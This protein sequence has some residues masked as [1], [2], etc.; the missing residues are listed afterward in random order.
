MSIKNYTTSISEDKTV[1]E[2]MGLLA[3][4]GARSIRIDYDELN[5]PSAVSFTVVIQDWPVPF[6]LPC[7]FDGVFKAM[8]A[9]RTRHVYQWERDPKNREQSRRVAWRIIKD[10]V[11][12]QMAL[13]EAEQAS[14]A[15]VFLPYAVVNPASGMTAFDQFMLQ[16]TSQ[17]VLS[18]GEP[19]LGG[20]SRGRKSFSGG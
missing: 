2:I 14:L 9:E 4:K 8:K 17:K 13:I 18:A 6:K 11:A 3:G 5:R 16:A 12:A 19:D 1:G 15:Q 20:H 10:W 7:S